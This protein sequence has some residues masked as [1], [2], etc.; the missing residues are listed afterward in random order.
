[1]CLW[2]KWNDN[3]K[4][5]K[6][7]NFNQKLTYTS[8]D[9]NQ[10]TQWNNIG[11]Y[12]INHITKDSSIKTK[13]IFDYS[14]PVMKNLINHKT[15]YNIIFIDGSHEYLDVLNDSKCADKLIK[16]EVLLFMMMF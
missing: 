1:M 4:R 5:S 10:K 9:P 6:N 8:I 13:F 15:R 11:I 2:N 14:T 3:N 16:K 12:N 7:F